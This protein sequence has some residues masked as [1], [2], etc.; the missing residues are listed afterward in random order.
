MGGDVPGYIG[1]QVSTIVLLS[2]F[3]LLCSGNGT[4][5]VTHGCLTPSIFKLIADPRTLS[6]NTRVAELISSHRCWKKEVLE[7]EFLPIDVKCIQSIRPLSETPFSNEIVLHFKLTGQFTGS[8]GVEE[9]LGIRAAHCALGLEDISHVRIP[10]TF[11]RLVWA[12][13]G[14]PASALPM[15][16][17][18]SR[19]NLLI[20]EGNQFQAHEVVVM[21]R[22]V[23]SSMSSVMLDDPG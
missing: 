11:A 19:C 7:K 1:T 14:L 9:R 10:C 15:H 3:K 21:A 17:L 20:L 6:G 23:L 5:P 12:L 8:T 16:G 13:L 4:F 18:W 22:R 2:I